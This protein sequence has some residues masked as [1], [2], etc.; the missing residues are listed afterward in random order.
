M[1]LG[2]LQYCITKIE[3]MVSI[4]LLNHVIEIFDCDCG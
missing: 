1:H 3:A 4:A 2:N